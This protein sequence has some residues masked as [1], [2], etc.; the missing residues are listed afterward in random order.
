[1]DR[2][3]FAWGRYQPRIYRREP[4]LDWL[5]GVGLF[6]AALVLLGTHLGELPLRDWDEATVAQVAREIWQAPEG[7]RRWLF[8]TLWGQPYLNKPPLIHAL[9]ALCYHLGGGLEWTAR[10]PSVLLT[11][12]SV[13]FLYGVGR[14]LFP[15]R[16]TAFFGAAIYMTLL[17]VIRHGRLAMLD[18]PILCFEIL[19]IWCALR[20]RRD[21]RWCLGIG[22]ALGLLG[23]TKGLMGVLLGAI[24][25][26]FFAW[27]TPRLL[28]SFYLW[29]GLVLG[30]VP[31]IAWYVAQGLHYQSVFLTTNLIEQ[32]LN[33]IWTG[34]DGNSGP[35]WYY[36]GQLLKSLPWLI[37]FA[38]GV[39]LAWEHRNWSW[40]KLVL[41]W[42]GVYFAA[43]S[44]MITKLP[45]YILPLY[46]ALSLAGGAVLAQAHVWRSDRPYPRIWIG[47]LAGLAVVA[48]AAS[49]YYGLSTTDYR[50]VITLVTV[51]FTMTLTAI[52]IAHRDRQFVA[53]LLWGMYVALLLFVSS[54][55]WLWELNEAYPVKPVAEVIARQVPPGQVV[56]TSFDYE[57]PSLNFYSQRRVLHGTLPELE[58]YWLNSASPYLLIDL[59][60][61]TKLA[62]EPEA[63]TVQAPS[64]FILVSKPT[65]AQSK[66]L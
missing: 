9:I 59:E 35:P 10:L 41:V 65:Q 15:A 63:Q 40:A 8:P 45:W 26:L 33:R 12:L 53:L 60:T 36:L 24:V 7:S 11:A 1:M 56:Y 34:V 2:Q 64:G 66:E 13:V 39:Q 3:T 31:A 37:F 51:T 38:F 28:T 54:S 30:S 55:H 49:I 44:L 43:I 61:L 48:L 6:L 20:S 50:L 19:M 47:G 29:G 46:P 18:G 23:L 27:D 14:E 57:R 32:S 25:L 52:L 58:Q 62:L 16:Q 5:W 17:P 21:L 22:I 4:W 42:S